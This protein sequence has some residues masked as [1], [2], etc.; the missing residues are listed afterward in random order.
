MLEVVLAVVE[1]LG[2]SEGGGLLKEDADGVGRRVADDG[3]GVLQ[4][5]VLKRDRH[6]EYAIAWN[7]EVTR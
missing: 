4:Y 7:T 1:G 5:H 3:E 2:A 6:A